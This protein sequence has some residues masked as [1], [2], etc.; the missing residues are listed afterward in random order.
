MINNQMGEK[1][2]NLIKLNK[3]PAKRIK[4]T[5]FLNLIK[6]IKSIIKDNKK[7]KKNI[8]IK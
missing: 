5:G 8:L 3:K 1:V 6:Y 4:N 7:V 2:K